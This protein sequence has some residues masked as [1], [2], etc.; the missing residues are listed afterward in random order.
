MITRQPQSLAVNLGQPFA[1]TVE[2]AGTEP[3]AFQW[4]RNGQ[5]LPG[6]TLAT[7]TVA[8]A[9]PRDAG[10]YSVLVRNAGGR[11][12]STTATVQL[13]T[14]PAGVFAFDRAAYAWVATN[15]QFVAAVLRTGDTSSVAWVEF[16]TADGTA[17]AGAD[18]TAT[19][20]ALRFAP[21]ETLKTVVVPVGGS[22][23]EGAGTVL[24]RL[25]NP[26]DPA[27]RT[28]R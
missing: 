9:Q 26:S 14:S 11:V 2:A 23:G 16:F 17:Q 3:F 21:G 1:L 8:A 28:A 20:A 12:T 15:A 19:A 6:A 25:A 27:L 24:L 22:T 18:Y 4:S 7:Y 5:P 13:T 10:L